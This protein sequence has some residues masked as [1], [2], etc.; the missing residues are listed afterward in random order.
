MGVVGSGE[1]QAQNDGYGKNES[2]VKGKEKGNMEKVPQEPKAEK[3]GA[4]KK[5]ENGKT[6]K[7]GNNGGP[8]WE[9]KTT[10]TVKKGMKG[11]TPKK[12]CVKTCKAGKKSGCPIKGRGK[13]SGHVGCAEIDRML[14]ALGVNPN[15]A[16]LCTKAA[17]MKGH[18]KITG[19]AGDL[20]Q[21]IVEQEGEC[22]HMI[23]ATLGDLL[24]QPDYAG[25][26][27]EDGLENATVT[28]KVLHLLPFF[29]KKCSICPILELLWVY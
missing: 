25:L 27:Y 5:S 12:V 8:S 13:P 29:P 19:E 15:N 6:G 4:S 14:E 16:S 23:I 26:D 10:G 11:A 17:I 24:N 22:G 21:A 2:V 3:S 7:K 1:T 20:D 18:I 28:C 9:G